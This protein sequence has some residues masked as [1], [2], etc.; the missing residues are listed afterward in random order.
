MAD[1]KP[2]P[3]PASAPSA[4]EPIGSAT[5]EAAAASATAGDAS[6]VGFEVP[7]QSPNFV[8]GLA[9]AVGLG[10]L[11]AIVYAAVAIF[12]EREFAIL[13]VLIGIA[14]AFGFLRFGRTKGVLAGIVAAIIAIALYFV[15]IFVTTAGLF[16][17]VQGESFMNSLSLMLQN[18]SLV[19]QVYFED[20][21]GYVFVGISAIIA[22]VYAAGLAG[23]KLGKG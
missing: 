8:V 23:R 20:P 3:E 14:V 19:V 9:A 5:P 2:T 11:A 4:A 22:F 21:L 13:A 10:L 16:A 1:D 15:A 7:E 17:K 6:P 18:A 12:A